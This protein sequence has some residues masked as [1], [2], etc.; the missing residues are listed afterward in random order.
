ML[1]AVHTA[2]VALGVVTSFSSWSCLFL[3]VSASSYAATEG[4]LQSK[5]FLPRRRTYRQ[6]VCSLAYRHLAG[7]VSS[8]VGDVDPIPST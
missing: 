2:H 5:A 1:P 3:S 4:K 7:E 6:D 8:A